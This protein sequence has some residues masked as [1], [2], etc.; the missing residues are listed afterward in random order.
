MKFIYALLLT[1]MVSSV[2]ATQLDLSGVDSPQKNN[3]N[4]EAIGEYFYGQMN[5][6]VFS[7]N[8]Y[9]NPLV[10]RKYVQLTSVQAEAGYTLLNSV[11]GKQIF[12][13]DLTSQADATCAGAT[14]LDFEENDGTNIWTIGIGAFST[15]P[16]TLASTS[17]NSVVISSLGVVGATEGQAVRV[18]AA[19]SA[20]TTCNYID[21]SLEYMV[22]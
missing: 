12:L 8:A 4:W 21:I 15:T 10:Y 7:Q 5:T 11:A 22:Q 6:D 20:L 1:F 9:D 13:T 14:S 18:V 19:G 3:N 2:G 17:G 16:I